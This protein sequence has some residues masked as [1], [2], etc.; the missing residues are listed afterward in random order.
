VMPR[1]GGPVRPTDSWLTDQWGAWLRDMDAY[2]ARCLEGRTDSESWEQLAREISQRL[3][4]ATR[5]LCTARQLAETQ[6]R[7]D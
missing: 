5:L 1:H 2:T 7:R 3:E 6:A 4:E